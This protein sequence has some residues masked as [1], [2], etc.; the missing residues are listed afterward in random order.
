MEEYLEL[1]VYNEPEECLSLG[2]HLSSMDDDGYC[3]HCGFQ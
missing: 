2:V 1:D 3:N